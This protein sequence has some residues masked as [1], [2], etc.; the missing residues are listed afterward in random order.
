MPG[1]RRP[2]A[3]DPCR[4]QRSVRDKFSLHAGRIRMEN[5]EPNIDQ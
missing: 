1:D 4:L 3:A 5:F 2:Q